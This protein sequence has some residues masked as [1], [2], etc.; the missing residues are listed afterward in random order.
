MTNVSPP[1]HTEAVS[2]CFRLEELQR[3]YFWVFEFHIDSI[4]Y[5]NVSQDA[6]FVFLEKRFT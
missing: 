1:T 2:K 5:L 6:I 4:L 3:F